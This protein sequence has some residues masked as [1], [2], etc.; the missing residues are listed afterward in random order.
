MA[1][2]RPTTGRDASPRIDTS[3]PHSARVWNY[4]LGGKDNYEV[5][6]TAGDAYRAHAPGIQ[7]MAR[8]SRRFLIRAVT[9]VAGDLG[10]R[11]FLDIGA[12]LPAYDN[13][14]QIAQ[15][16]APTSRVV[17]VDNDPLVIRHAQAL[18]G[19]APEGVTDFVEADLRGPEEIVERAGRT[20]DLGRPVAVMLMGVLG[21]IE[22]HEEAK[23]V[24]RRLL[25]A[26]PSGSFL[27][28]YDSTDTDPALKEA[29]Q[30]YDDTGAAPY[31]LRSPE[32]LTD[33]YEGLDVLAPGIVS[34]P[35]WRP[36]PGTSPEPAD[37]YGGAARKP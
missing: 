25:A 5:D 36:E 23:S 30:G 29:Q 2:S 24:V 7:A 31:A 10:V 14:H 17:Y 4:W 6:R 12:G 21:H 33:Y 3:V 18:L 11:Q 37:I 34:C 27:V 35:L 20:L 32:Q 1:D 16:L 15:R 9:H 28:H 13:T 19:S 8:A 22:D 26:L